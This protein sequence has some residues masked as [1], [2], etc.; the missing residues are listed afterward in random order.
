MRRRP[1]N[2]QEQAAQQ[3][4]N[5]EMQRRLQHLQVAKHVSAQQMQQQQMQR[6]QQADAPPRKQPLQQAGDW[7]DAAQRKKDFLLGSA[8]A[9]VAPSG[10]VGTGAF[11]AVRAVRGGAGGKQLSAVKTYDPQGDP[12]ALQHLRNELALAGRIRHP[13]ILGPGKVTELG[14]GKVEIAMDYAS[15]GSVADYVKRAKYASRDGSALPEAEAAALFIGLVDAVAYL[16]S[17]EVSHGDLKL[18]NAMLDDGIVRLIDFGTARHEGKRAEAE[19]AGAVLAG[20]L[21]YLAPEAL[22][23]WSAADGG[24]WLQLNYDGRPAD[25]WA[26]GVCLVN[27]LSCGDFPFVGAD[28]EALQRAVTSSNPTLPE[29]ISDG[30]RELIGAMLTK[31][32]ARRASVGKVRAHPWVAAAAKRGRQTS[33]DPMVA[34]DFSAAFAHMLPS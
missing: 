12:I 14:G 4:A 5:D 11:A 16:H 26:L 3:Q 18:G 34:T 31:E 33:S 27:L 9:E 21:P 28:Q 30:A 6:V 17:S 19:G 1:L 22:P 10:R 29:R 32:P 20:T 2:E 8:D 13:N 25:V 15:G 7:N 23:K 24:R